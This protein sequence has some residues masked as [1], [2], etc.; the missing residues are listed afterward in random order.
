MGKLSYKRVFSKYNITLSDK[1]ARYAYSLYKKVRI[2]LSKKY[3]LKDHER[4]IFEDRWVGDH[5]STDL[6]PGFN[7]SSKE[8]EDGYLKLEYIDFYDYLPKEDLEQFKS[9]LNNFA[10]KNKTAYFSS[11]RTAKDVERIDSMGRYFD[12]SAFSN[13]HTIELTHNEYLEKYSSQVAV[14]LKNLSSSFLVV[15]YRFYT[16]SSFNE[17]IDAICKTKYA[18]YTDVFRHLNIPWYKPQ[19]FG[20]SMHTGNAARTKAL[21]TLI[22][23][24]KWEVFIELKKYFKIYFERNQLFPPTFE[25]YSTNI[26][27][28]ISSENM[29]FWNSVMHWFNPEYMPKCNACVCWGYEHGQYEGMKLSACCG[30]SYSDSEHL[31]EYA[32]HELS[33]IYAVYMVA[34]SIRRIAERDIAICNKKISKAVRKARTS[35]VLKMRVNVEQKLYYSYRFIS[36]FSGDT[37]DYDEI[38]DFESDLDKGNSVTARCLSGIS[39]DTAETK[40]QIDILLHILDDAAEYRSAKSN[41]RLQWLMMLITIISLFVAVLALI[42]FDITVLKQWWHNITDLEWLKELVSISRS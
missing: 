20:K 7:F 13:L 36:E 14:S 30:G 29:G 31:P 6:P 18:P 19:K 5:T 42:D 40:E 39:K 17:K 3:P 21:Y 12:W 24:F 38:A 34:S 37:I 9:A 23:N 28:N 11:F 1:L 8:T 33:N 26:R 15:K 22:S 10:S 41:M 35:L 4:F 16:S 2:G 32:K 27:T 25:T